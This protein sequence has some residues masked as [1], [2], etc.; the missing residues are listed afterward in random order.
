MLI[1]LELSYLHTTT[2]FDRSRDHGLHNITPNIPIPHSCLQV[3]SA[4]ACIPR[5]DIREGQ[6]PSS[7]FSIAWPPEQ[8]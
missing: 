7:A 1:E 2:L 6:S 3:L 5:D 8:K 4:E